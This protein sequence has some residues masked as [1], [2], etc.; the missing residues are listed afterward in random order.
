VHLLYH[1]AV[2]IAWLGGVAFVASLAYLGYFYAVTLASPAGAGGDWAG[3]LATNI[4]LFSVFALHH[5]LLA[6]PSAKRVVTRLVPSRYERTLYVWVASALAIVVCALW[7][8]V[9]GQVY[10]VEGWRRLPFWLTQLAGLVL[11]MRA[12]RVV[13]AL[14]LAG[15]DQ[16]RGRNGTAALKV[17]GPFRVVRH[18]I[19][20]GWIL[21]VFGT[22]DMTANRLVFAAISTLYLILAI[23]WEERS[24]V[25]AYGDPYRAYQRLVR[26]RLVPGVW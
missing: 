3:P 11:V 21:L 20:L 5:S 10:V 4:A 9:A 25:A 1:L 19:Y 17:A 26:W 13:S 2:L 7:H 24:L 14:E 16:A 18:P 8:P 6:R 22:P 23:P 15:I 12:A